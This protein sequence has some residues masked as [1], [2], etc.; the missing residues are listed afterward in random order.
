MARRLFLTG[1]MGCGK[2]T[3]GRRLA[4]A[5]GAGW[6][7]LDTDHEI[8]RRA[9]MTVSEIF[10]NGGEEAFRELERQVIAEAAASER[11]I[12]VALGGGSVCREG[13]M[14]M[15]AAAGTTVYLKTSPARL[16]RRMSERG[17]AKR[18]KIAGMSDEELLAYIEKTLP[19]RE[20]YYNMATF[21]LDCGKL[22]GKEV[23]ALLLKQIEDL[24]V[25]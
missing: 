14:E 10:A 11:D 17:R 4:R 13:M 5:A 16:V 1:F 9:G 6:D 8:E 7:F 12:I 23:I 18:P 2:S 24:N 25:K 22:S 20:K 19:D 15:L 3:F 21:V